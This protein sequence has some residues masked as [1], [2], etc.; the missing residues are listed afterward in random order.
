MAND[1]LPQAQQLF[2]SVRDLINRQIGYMIVEVE[3][4]GQSRAEYGKALI[5]ELSQSLTT[6]FGKGFDVS[7]L[8]HMRSVYLAFPK[9]DALRR[10]LS[11]THY[12][13]LYRI[14]NEQA[15]CY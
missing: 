10:E 15:S 7:N 1:S 4:Q 8:R 12:R 6:E 14:E 5:K 2:E 13:S 3:Q 11:W 9:H